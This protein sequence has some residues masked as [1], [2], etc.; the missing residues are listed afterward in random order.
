MSC[1]ALKVGGLTRSTEDSRDF[2][3]F[4]F[5]QT[6]HQPRRNLCSYLVL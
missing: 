1:N 3:F 2:A 5:E 6:K 4:V